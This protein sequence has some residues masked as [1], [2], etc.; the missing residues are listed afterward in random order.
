MIEIVSS[1][2]GENKVLF[3]SKHYTLLTLAA[4]TV[5]RLLFPFEW[6]H[7]YIPILP[8]DLLEFL[9]APTPYIIG[10]HIDILDSVQDIPG[11]MIVDLDNGTITNENVCFLSLFY[12]LYI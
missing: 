8:I 6:H 3:C 12:L 10:I 9:E 7:I 1:L 4:E 2:L 11:L 5:I